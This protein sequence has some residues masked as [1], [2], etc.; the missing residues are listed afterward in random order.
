MTETT[1]A[2]DVQT[3]TGDYTI[4]AAHSRIGF[5]ARHAMLTKVR[6]AFTDAAGTA[7][8]DFINPAASTAE[9]TL[10]VKSINTG[11][12]Q[13]D[14]HLRTNDFFDAPTYPEITFKSSKVEKVSDDTY[15]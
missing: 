11:Q 1:T 12:E 2:L 8:L 13:R 3:L 15:K 10:Q 14:E 9:V 4:D 7:H 6:G 5:V